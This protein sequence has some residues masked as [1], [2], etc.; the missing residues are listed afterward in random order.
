MS[1][2]AWANPVGLISQGKGGIQHIINVSAG[3]DSTG[4][5]VMAALTLA[6]VL[7]GSSVQA[8][9]PEPGSEDADI[10]G[11]YADWVEH[12]HDANGAW[13]CTISDGR[14]VEARIS[15]ASWEV[16]ITPDKFPGS[17]DH[18]QAVPDEKVLRVPNPTGF[19]IAWVMNDRI[20]CFAPPS[21]V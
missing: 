14:T 7:F 8:A 6:A 16:H 20:F 3:K 9:P 10:M 18:W 5:Y 19:P 2:A 13:C 15:G 1:R 11:P 17:H 21:G 4:C 12:Q